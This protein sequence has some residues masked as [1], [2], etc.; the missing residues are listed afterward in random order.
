MTVIQQLKK[1]GAQQQQQQQQQQKQQQ[2]AH[3][4]HQQHL[5]ATEEQKRTA[6]S[7]GVGGVIYSG[8][9]SPPHQSQQVPTCVHTYCIV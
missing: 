4:K 9:F 7:K 3:M 5:V 6:F 8:P 2:H 1:H